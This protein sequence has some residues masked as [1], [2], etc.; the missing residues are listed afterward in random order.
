MTNTSFLPTT[1]IQWAR[2]VA[3]IALIFG[4]ITL[5]SGG[6]VLFGPQEARDSA[7]NFVGF[8]VWFNFLAGGA[9]VAAAVGLWMRK[10]WSAHLATLIAAATAAVALGFAVLVLRGAAFEMR[11]VGAMALRFAFWAAVALLAHRATR[12]A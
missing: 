5:L 11:T 6:G 10:S 3:V 12:K 2:P 7:G 4:V 1:A 8:V 9:Y